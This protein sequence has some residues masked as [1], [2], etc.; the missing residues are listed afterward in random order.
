MKIF[1]LFKMPRQASN[2]SLK[3]T[4]VHLTFKTH[5]EVDNLIE[6][7]A[8]C[9]KKEIKHFSVVHENADDSDPYEHTH[10]LIWF[11]KQVQSK[12]P[13]IFDLVVNDEVI[14]PNI[15]VVNTDDHWK[16]VWCYHEKNPVFL[17]PLPH[18][19]P[20]TA[21]KDL[22]SAIKKAPSLAAAMEVA[23]LQPRSLTDLV[24]LRKDKQARPPAKASYTNF[25]IPSLDNQ[26]G[27]WRVVV[28]HGKAGTG[29][30][31]FG[32][33]QFESPLLVSHT[34]DLREF[35]PEK[36]TGI[37]FDDMSFAH[38]PR[39]SIIHLL[40]Y[41][42][43]RSIHCRYSCAY[44]PAR[45]KKI[46]TSN[47]APEDIFGEAW[48]H[49]AIQRRITKVIEVSD[50]LFEPQIDEDQVP[51]PPTV[52]ELRAATQELSKQTI[53]DMRVWQDGKLIRNALGDPTEVVPPGLRDVG[54]FSRSQDDWEEREAA[55]LECDEELDNEL[56]KL[57]AIADRL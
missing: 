7:I 15:K 8:S 5:L 3:A 11:K 52:E 41:D 43:D 48:H 17:A 20:V 55:R 39:E 54:I 32:L 10:A 56:D 31:Q 22:I 46:F 40:D 21:P 42:L 45:T 53:Y 16:N 51:P 14:H 50:N 24:L 4:R 37:V 18:S 44:I 57:E 26:L 27:S 34:D 47:R 13:R 35:D 28:I 23:D 29:K 36:H 12:N 2:F 25:T 33:A 30:T 6:H 19:N 9:S 49:P 1:S 38:H